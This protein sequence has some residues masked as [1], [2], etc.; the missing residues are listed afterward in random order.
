MKRSR[1]HDDFS[2]QMSITVLCEAGFHN[3]VFYMCEERGDYDDYDQEVIK[4]YLKDGDVIYNLYGHES[5]KKNASFVEGFNKG[6]GTFAVAD[7]LKQNF[8]CLY[9][10]S[11]HEGFRAGRE[12]NSN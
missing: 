6:S 3:T 4:D 2:V 5:D 7:E 8:L 10:L 12:L 1:T 9:A 11:Y